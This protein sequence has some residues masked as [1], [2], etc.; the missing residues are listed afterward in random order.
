M[1]TRSLIGYENDDGTVTFVYCHADGFVEYVGATLAQHYQVAAQIAALLTLGDLSSLGAALGERHDFYVRPDNVCTF[2]GRDRGE[3]DVAAKTLPDAAMF[4][5]CGGQW[6][7]E[8]LYLYQDGAWWVQPDDG[9]PQLLSEALAR[10]K[11]A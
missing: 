2:Y 7:A 5:A 10:L 11:A 3:A 9:T 6:D 4:W 8:F 1:S